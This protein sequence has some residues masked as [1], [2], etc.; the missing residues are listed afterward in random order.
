MDTLSMKYLEKEWNSVKLALY[1]Y[2]THLFA[3]YMENVL[4]RYGKSVLSAV[5]FFVTLLS[6]SYSYA[7][8]LSLT[9]VGT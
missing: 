5:A 4:A 6:L 1:F 2:S 9:N 7:A 8:F 3:Q